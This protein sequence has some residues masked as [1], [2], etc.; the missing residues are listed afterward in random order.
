MD[1]TQVIEYRPLD[2]RNLA[3][4]DKADHVLQSRAGDDSTTNSFE[5]NIVVVT[6]TLA[7]GD[8]V[9]LKSETD[10]TVEDGIR[11]VEVMPTVVDGWTEECVGEL[12]ISNESLMIDSDVVESVDNHRELSSNNDVL[13]VP[14][15]P[16]SCKTTADSDT[17]VEVK[18]TPVDMQSSTTECIRNSSKIFYWEKCTKDLRNK[19]EAVVN[20]S[21]PKGNDCY[22]VNLMKIDDI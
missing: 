13:D 17:K 6:N 18:T 8:D 10:N 7:P 15:I 9:L 1:C 22:P 21:K 11:K 19:K 4:N 5:H 14:A 20:V 2:G 3:E 16:A 12:K